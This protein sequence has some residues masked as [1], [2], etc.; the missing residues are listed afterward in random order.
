MKRCFGM[1]SKRQQ[2]KQKHSTLVQ[3]SQFKRSEGNRSSTTHRVTKTTIN[4]DK[5]IINLITNSP[6]ESKPP[7]IWK[8]IFKDKRLSSKWREL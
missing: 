1:Q 6:N 3:E 7:P 4:L 5:S 8:R 2:R